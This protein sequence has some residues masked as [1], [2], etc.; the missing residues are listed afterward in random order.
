MFWEVRLG[1]HSQ[2][3]NDEQ[4]STLGISQVFH[5]PWYRGYD[6][7]IAVMKL[8]EPIKVTD[9]VRPICI[10][11]AQTSF[12]SKECFATGWGKI[13][14]SEYQLFKKEKYVLMYLFLPTKQSLT[15]SI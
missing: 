10:P 5:Y 11:D 14:Y 7:D 12:F 8:T 9:F 13:D 15:N 6:N 4:E 2:K 1:E 3:N